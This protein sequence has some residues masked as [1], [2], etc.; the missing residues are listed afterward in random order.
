MPRRTYVGEME[1][2]LQ[3]I[4]IRNHDRN[5]NRQAHVQAATRY[6]IAVANARRSRA[7]LPERPDMKRI[8]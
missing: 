5:N 6:G 7:P 8:A 3:E 2:A 1:W 4:N